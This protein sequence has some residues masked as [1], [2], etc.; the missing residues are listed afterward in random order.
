MI[1]A[2]CV[3]VVA[4]TAVIVWRVVRATLRK[5][6][7]I[8]ELEDTTYRRFGL[9]AGLVAD[10]KLKGRHLRINADTYSLNDETY[11]FDM[12]DNLWKLETCAP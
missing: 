10:G 12:T 8:D 3:I 4:L 9:K 2:V 11:V 7:E 5:L 6:N 1:W